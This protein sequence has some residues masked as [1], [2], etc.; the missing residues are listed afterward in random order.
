MLNLFLSY[1]ISSFFVFFPS[2]YICFA[3]S[4][5]SLFRA[6]E[7]TDKVIIATNVLPVGNVVEGMIALLASN[8]VSARLRK[9]DRWHVTH[10]AKDVT[11]VSLVS[12]LTARA[13]SIRMIKNQPTV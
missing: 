9:F 11:E 5:A 2:S 7:S 13:V 10:A 4:L 1:I 8:V 3:S 6:V 12:A